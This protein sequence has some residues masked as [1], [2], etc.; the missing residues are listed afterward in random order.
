MKKPISMNEACEFLGLKKSYVYKLTAQ[1][2]IPHYKSSGGK[3]LYFIADD[4]RQ[5]ALSK[6]KGEK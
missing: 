1:G 3:K 5:W 4:L 2:K 6:R